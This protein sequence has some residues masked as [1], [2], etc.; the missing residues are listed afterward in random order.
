M[1]VYTI[2]STYYRK[3][4]LMYGLSSLLAYFWPRVGIRCDKNAKRKV[5]PA[6]PHERLHRDARF[7]SCRL[8][9]SFWLY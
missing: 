2:Y 9:F 1:V 4:Q 5:P 8:R 3:L 7:R 6:R